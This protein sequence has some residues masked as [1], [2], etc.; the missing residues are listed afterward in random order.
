M[1]FAVFI[2]RHGKLLVATA[3]AF[4][5]LTTVSQA[6]TLEQEQMC[7]GDA[8]RLCSAE[9]PNVDRITACMERQRDLLSDGCKAIFEVEPAAPEAPA[10][11]SSSAKPSKPLNLMP[12]K[13]G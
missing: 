12:N 5:M 8:M 6:Y 7:S 4:G 2:F 13:R 10:A 9:I 3:L 11:Y 1:A